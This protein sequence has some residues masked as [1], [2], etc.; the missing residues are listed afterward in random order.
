MSD[1]ALLSTVCSTGSHPELLAKIARSQNEDETLDLVVR[2]ILAE[3]DSHYREEMEIPPLAQRAFEDRDHSISLALSR[4]RL[5]MYSNRVHRMAPQLVEACPSFAREAH[6]WRELEKR[7]LPMI[8]DRYEWDIA[9]AFIHSLRRMVNKGEWKAVE[10][11]LEG[12]AKAPRRCTDG[13]CRTFNVSSALQPET[14]AELLRIPGLRSPFRD[15]NEDSRLVAERVNRLVDL[16]DSPLGPIEAIQIIDAGFFRN[17]G[18]YLVG[19]IVSREGQLSPLIIALLNSVDGLYV[20]AVLTAV[21]DAHNCFSS[22]L[23]NFH[24]T[25]TAYHEVARFLHSIMPG[26]PLGLHYTTIG[27]NHLGKVAIMSELEAEIESTGEVFEPS[28]GSRGTV[29]IGFCTPSSA[30]NLKVIRNHPTAGYKW[31]EFAGIESVKA[32]YARV[33]EINRTGSMLDNVIYYN[34]KLD[35]SWFA[36]DLLEELLQEASE[37]VVQQGDAVVFKFLIAQLRLTPLPVYLEAASTPDAEI[38]ISNLGYC[39]KNNAAANV[40]NK[41]LDAR[42]YGVSRY[43]KVYLFDYDA[44]V[45]LEEVKI[46][47]NQDRIDGDEEIPEWYFEDG[48][49]FLPEEVEVGLCIRDRHLRRTLRETHPELLTTEYWEAIQ[50]EIREGGVPSVSVYPDERRLRPDPEDW[51]VTRDQSSSANSPFLKYS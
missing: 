34:V 43:R 17:R 41:D 40:F 19:R 36:P 14:V 13:I 22:T 4:R 11:T 1:S 5:S 26:R 24:V 29:A 38:V 25:N 42:N 50:R 16:D 31:G 35:R 28:V 6:L 32:K 27:Y 10:Y 20:D 44:L 30:Y 45:P 51:D 9:A 47:T 8:Q 23:A 12:S 18:A 15:I 48:F 49:V 33:H 2:W 7:Y 21:T 3:F 39:I 37:S 46:R